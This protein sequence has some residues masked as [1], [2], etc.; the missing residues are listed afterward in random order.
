MHEHDLALKPLYKL[1]RLF[2]KKLDT[3]E[4][5]DLK[6]LFYMLM[7]DVNL[8]RKEFILAYD[9]TLKGLAVQNKHGG[10]K[11]AAIVR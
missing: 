6:V 5:R 8:S 2:E 4:D 7:A 9:F 10:A 1:M 3:D 11:V